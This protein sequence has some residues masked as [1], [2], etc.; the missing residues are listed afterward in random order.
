MHSSLNLLDAVAIT[1][2]VLRARMHERMEGSMSPYAIKA[3]L[4]DRQ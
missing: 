3:G 4:S 2:P 1:R